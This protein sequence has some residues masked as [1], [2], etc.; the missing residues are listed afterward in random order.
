M[1]AHL[2]KVALQLN[3]AII[4]STSARFCAQLTFPLLWLAPFL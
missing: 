3:F 2:T 4:S 1:K